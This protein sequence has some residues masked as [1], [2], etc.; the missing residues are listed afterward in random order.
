MTAQYFYV[1]VAEPRGNYPGRIEEGWFIFD[2]SKVVLTNMNGAPMIGRTQASRT[3]MW[4]G[5]C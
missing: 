4:R 2:G 3:L 5:E 1:V